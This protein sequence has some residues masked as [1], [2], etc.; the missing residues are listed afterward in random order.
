MWTYF[1]P[2]KRMNVDLKRYGGV[3]TVL[4]YCV[5]KFG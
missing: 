5:A 2:W 3:Y 1:F 4:A